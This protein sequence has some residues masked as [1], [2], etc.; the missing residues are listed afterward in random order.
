MFRALVTIMPTSSWG[1]VTTMM[2]STG[3]DW[4]HGEGHVA[5]ARRHVHEEVVH[6]PP[7]HVGPELLHRPGDDGAPP[8]H[9][10]GLMLHE[11]VEAHDL[12]TGLGDRRVDAQ[13]AALGLGVDA[14]G[15]GDGGAGDVGVQHAHLLAQ[16]AH[17]HRQGGGHQA[18]AHAPLAADHGDDLAHVDRPFTGTWRSWGSVRSAQLSPQVEQLCVQSDMVFVPSFRFDS[19]YKGRCRGDLRSPAGGQRPPL[20]TGVSLPAAC[21]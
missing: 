17:G 16:P 13:L 7:D 4:K 11:Q 19:Y 15:G 12:D 20:Q 8:H 5:G 10:V 1:E 2:P 9:R 6:V 3:R 21:Q 14:E 18:L